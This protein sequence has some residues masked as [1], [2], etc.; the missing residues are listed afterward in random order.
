VAGRAIQ[1][2]AMIFLG[3]SIDT[4]EWLMGNSAQREAIAVFDALLVAVKAAVPKPPPDPE[5]EKMR[6]NVETLAA[7]VLRLEKL[8]APPE[9][10]FTPAKVKRHVINPRDPK[11]GRLMKLE[12]ALVG[13]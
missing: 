11:T 1:G 13:E 2:Q 7:E 3:T 10:P 6:R 4:R 8:L 12:T 9:E 5:L